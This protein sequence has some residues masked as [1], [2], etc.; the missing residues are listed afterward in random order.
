MLKI[1]HYV[2]SYK[3]FLKK[4]IG[5]TLKIKSNIKT[6]LGL[7]FSFLIFKKRTFFRSIRGMFLFRQHRL[8]MRRNYAKKIIKFR[9]TLMGFNIPFHS[10]IKLKK[11]K[12]SF[13]FLNQKKILNY[14][15]FE[16]MRIKSIFLLNGYIND[17]LFFKKVKNVNNIFLNYK[18]DVRSFINYYFKF[19]KLNAFLARHL[20]LTSFLLNNNPALVGSD[21]YLKAGDVLKFIF[22][23]RLLKYFLKKKVKIVTK[24]K[25]RN[26]FSKR[27]LLVKLNKLRNKNKKKRGDIF[28]K[29]REALNI[30]PKKVIKQLTKRSIFGLFNLKKKLRRSIEFRYKVYKR[31]VKKKF[32]DS[33]TKE[34]SY[35]FFTSKSK[36]N[37]YKRP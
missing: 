37:I 7:F 29:V 28:S 33:E 27:V 3:F 6:S 34:K 24:L 14:K 35:S 16:P 32:L 26:R 22:S 36:E 13:K 17:R 23:R 15:F 25:K 1:L 31:L 19:F 4:K 5:T 20:R 10:R 2:Y 12:K 8:F 9:S 21:F 30:K 11:R 18:F